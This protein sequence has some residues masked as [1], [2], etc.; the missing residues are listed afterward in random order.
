MKKSLV[1]NSIYNILY[2]V[3]TALYPL[4]AVTYVSHV[5]EAEKMG[6]VS[7][8]QNI[9]SYFA[10]IAALGLPTYGI[11]EI[12]KR[13]DDLKSRSKLYYELLFIN[14]MSTS[15]S[16]IVYL[17]LVFSVPQFSNNKSLYFVAGLQIFFNYMNVD[18]F[19][20]GM[21]EYSIYFP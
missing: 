7:Y 2:K 6:M 5:L 11:R 15:I 16:L 14:F 13:A 12:A 19:F 20:Q 4:V 3:V 9:V 8:A 10:V 1:E 21:E 17:V 18:W